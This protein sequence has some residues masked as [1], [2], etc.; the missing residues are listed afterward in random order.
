MRIYTL[1]I[2]I[3]SDDT[4]EFIEETIVNDD[5]CYAVGGI[6]MSDYWDASTS[7]LD[8]DDDIGEA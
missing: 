2:G 8:I 6:D 7:L 3:N 4:C 5:S 1:R